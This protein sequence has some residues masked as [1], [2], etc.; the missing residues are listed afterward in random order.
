[1]SIGHD[2]LDIRAPGTIRG[3]HEQFRSNTQSLD[4]VIAQ[5]VEEKILK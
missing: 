5:V 1:M 2:Q 3:P 4:R